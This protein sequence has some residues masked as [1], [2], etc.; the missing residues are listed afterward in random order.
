[1]AE[2][3]RRLTAEITELVELIDYRAAVMD[4]ALAQL[5][6]IVHYWSGMLMFSQGSHPW[7]FRLAQVAVEVGAF[8]VFQY[9]MR[10]NRPRPSQLC[11]WLMPPVAV[12]PHASFPSGHSTQAHLLSGLLQEVLPAEVTG[13]DPNTSLLA[14]MAERVARHREVLGLHYK[15]DTAAGKELATQLKNLLID[16]HV[17]DDI[18]QE[19]LKEW[20]PRR[21]DVPTPL[22][23]LIA[24]GT[25]DKDEQSA[26][27]R[28]HGIDPAQLDTWKRT[29][30]AA[31]G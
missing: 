24:T 21:K 9:K 12:P 31:L 11:P 7:T 29:A 14:R 10:D 23:A 16:H 25:M 26:Y 6:D 3:H 22:D 17:V 18:I 15:S 4:E 20:P 1:M 30:I 5:T 2:R 8:V 28:S 13:P 27:C 19:A